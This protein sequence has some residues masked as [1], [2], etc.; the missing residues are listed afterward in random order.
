MAKNHKSNMVKFI[1]LDLLEEMNQI[2]TGEG[3]CFCSKNGDFLCLV[4]DSSILRI[5]RITTGDFYSHGIVEFN[6]NEIG[7]IFMSNKYAAITF[8]KSSS[9]LLVDLN[10]CQI[11]EIFPY[12][13]NFCAFSPDDKVILIHSEKSLNYFILDSQ[14]GIE[15]KFS[16]SSLEIP[17]LVVFSNNNRKIFSL[18]KDTKQIIFYSLNLEKNFYNSDYIIQDRDI[19]DMKVTFDETRLLVLSLSCVYVFDIIAD[20]IKCVHKLRANT[21][22]IINIDDKMSYFNGFGATIDSKIVYVT[23]YSYLIC[24]DMLSGEVLRLFQ[25]SLSAN[26]ILKSCASKISDIMLS[27]LDNGSII[28]WNLASLKVDA[29]KFDDMRVHNERVVDC[30]LTQVANNSTDNSSLALSYCN[31]SPDAKIQCLNDKFSVKSIIND[32][33][34][35]LDNPLQTIIKLCAMDDTGTYCFILTEVTEF[36]GKQ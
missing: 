18:F 22:D 8:R 31:L 30:F 32:S 24:Y 4:E 7:R 14:N 29:M 15:R 12:S 27:L 34:N 28:L 33:Y 3:K 6:K 16:L 26:R 11:V 36:K 13:T 25:S 21:L 19:T 23:I 2:S 20:D 1:D 9:P 17:E 5:K 35:G 10:S